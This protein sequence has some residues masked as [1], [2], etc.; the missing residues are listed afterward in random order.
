[1][2]PDTENYE[3]E[4]TQEDLVEESIPDKT[5]RLDFDTMTIGGFI[6]DEDA[7]RQ[8]IQK[9][10]LTES[11]VDPIYDPSYGRM[12]DDL[13]GEPMSYAVSEAKDRIQDA[14]LQ[15]DRFSEVLFTE[16]MAGK[17]KVMLSMRVICAD[18]S[19]IEIEGVS[20]DV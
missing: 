10:L 3:E 19:E 18:G 7:K 16:Q 14:I 13:I 4:Q 20:V 11:E 9:V 8:A 1:M 5:Y 12:F 6:D 15:D 2:L 17:R